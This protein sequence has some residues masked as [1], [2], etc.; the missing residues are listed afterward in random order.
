VLVT[1]PR[2]GANMLRIKHKFSS[3]AETRCYTVRS[4]G[5]LIIGIRK[6]TWA[7]SDPLPDHID[8]TTIYTR[9]TC[10]LCNLQISSYAEATLAYS[11]CPG[12]RF[13][14][15]LYRLLY[16]SSCTR[17]TYGPKLNTGHFTSTKVRHSNG[18]PKQTIRPASQ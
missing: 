7:K 10:L 17:G 8:I 5:F 12:T 14:L 2:Y 18:L 1:Y 16:I 3:A 13:T 11:S 6:H 4:A 15:V 9:T